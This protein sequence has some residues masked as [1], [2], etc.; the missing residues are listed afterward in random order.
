[1]AKKRISLTLNEEL[2]EKVDE[3]AEEKGVNRSRMVEDIIESYLSERKISTAVVFCGDPEAK[4]L[5]TWSGKPVL[6]HVLDDL[7]EYV[8][9]A[10]LLTG[11]NR[12]EI[13]SHF[14]SRHGEMALEYV[15]DEPEGTARALEKIENRIESSFLVVNGHV[16]SGVDIDEMLEVH[17][18][19]DRIATMA[20]TTVE[21][22]SEYGVARLKGRKI[23]GFEEK[24]EPG[25][26]P[27]RLINA[28][29]YIFEPEI[30]ERLNRHSIEEEFEKLAEEGKLTGYIYGGK[31]KDFKQG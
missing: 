31:W 25:E 15:S 28:G 12:E 26:E 10:I 4:A 19:E 7:S 22:P 23:L 30:F 3:E 27:S 29:T 24:P 20:L 2:V 16:I 18:E 11:P 8:S 13:E 6:G 21:N 5:N 9:R 17:R 14:G 1:M